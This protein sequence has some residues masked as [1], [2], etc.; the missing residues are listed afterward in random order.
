MTAVRR[1][2]AKELSTSL[3]ILLKRNSDLRARIISIG[4][5]ILLPDGKTLLRAG[6]IK[7]PP[8]RGENELKITDKMI[9]AWAHDG[10]IDLRIPNMQRWKQR[11]EEIV[12]SISTIPAGDSSSRFQRTAQ[13]WNNFGQIEPGKLVGW[14]FSEEEKGKR[15]KA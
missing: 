13:Y 9:N 12:Q 4:I 3:E 6:E 2:T 8:Y 7:I 1:S 11:F 14:I 10:W 5:P 15:M